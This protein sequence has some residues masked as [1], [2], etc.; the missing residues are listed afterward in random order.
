LNFHQREPWS[1]GEIA[2]NER[3]RARDTL[4]SSPRGSYY[5]FRVF[6]RASVTLVEIAG[7]R[8]ASRRLAIGQAPFTHIR[9]AGLFSN[10][11]ETIAR[12][13]P[14]FAITT[15]SLSRVLKWRRDVFQAPARIAA[16]RLDIR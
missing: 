7:F 1:S 2:A 4:G 16:S 8:S 13:R 6:G 15:A 14:P 12:P 3:T 11:A 5:L 10:S 9:V